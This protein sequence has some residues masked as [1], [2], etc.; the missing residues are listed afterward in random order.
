MEI[1]KD[2]KNFEETHQ[3]SNLGNI[4]TKDRYVYGKNHGVEFKR[5]V[6][7]QIMK[8]KVSKQGYNETQLRCEG[9]V[10][11]KR[12]HRLV[13]EAFIDNPNNYPQVNHKNGI[14]TDNR[15]ENLEWC[16]SKQNQQH[17]W[18]TGLQKHN[19]GEFKG[20]PVILYNDKGVERYFKSGLEAAKYL[21][22]HPSS[23]YRRLK[24]KLNTKIRGYF[25][26]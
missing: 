3:V 18:N 9:K 19:S 5:L 22:V 26:K 24:T 17:A 15:V 20:K 25:V 16:S 6:K 12:V 11:Y 4:R 2:I 13:A 14:K 1:Y 23:I 21:K 8:Q 10:L 7:G